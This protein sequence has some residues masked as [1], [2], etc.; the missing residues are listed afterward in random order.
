[1]PLTTDG[2]HDGKVVKTLRFH[3][4]EGALHFRVP[5]LRI[6]SVFV[7]GKKIQTFSSYSQ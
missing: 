7:L 2:Q 5:K 3:L 1:M 4:P 6:P